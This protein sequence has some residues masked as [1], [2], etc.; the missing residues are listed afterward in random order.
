[1]SA[2][3]NLVS[4]NQTAHLSNEFIS[5]AI[6]AA[7]YVLEAERQIDRNLQRRYFVPSAVH[8]MSYVEIHV[9]DVYAENPMSFKT[10]QAYMF[11]M[12]RNH[13]TPVKFSLN[14]ITVLKNR[15]QVVTIGVP[16]A[17]TGEW[18]TGGFGG[19]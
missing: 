6:S 2:F 4:Q 19:T 18:L 7:P 9:K 15:K 16:R 1:M 13:Q 8:Q 17:V 12:C 10:D 14:K 3:A 11:Y 5:A